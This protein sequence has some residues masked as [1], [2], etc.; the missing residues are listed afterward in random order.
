MRI[1]LITAGPGDSF[2]CENCLRD[3]QLARALRRA[4]HDCMIVSL[5]LPLNAE[6]ADAILAGTVAHL[7]TVERQAGLSAQRPGII[8]RR[9]AAPRRACR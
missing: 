9:P 4:G 5:Y 1:I 8:A 2:Y 7:M 6:V 3:G